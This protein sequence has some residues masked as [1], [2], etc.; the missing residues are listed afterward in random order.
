MK[1]NDPR[2]RAR[3][4][5]RKQILAA[6]K[7]VCALRG[8]HDCS[9]RHIAAEAELSPSVLY[10]YFRNKEEIIA[11]LSM[12]ILKHLVV[13]LTYLEKKERL[14]LEEGFSGL[15]RA[16]HDVYRVDPLLFRWVLEVQSLRFLA[17]VEKALLREIQELLD[18]ALAILTRLLT[19]WLS[20]SAADCAFGRTLAV[21][22]WSLFT[23]IMLRG[24]QESVL[25]A[26][27]NALDETL[28]VAFE[29]MARGFRNIAAT[30]G[31][32]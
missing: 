27:K 4:W 28:E 3:E 19:R 11:A 29:T 25:R 13:R 6:A 14:S 2:G 23:G 17:E 15:R 18:Q 30:R 21:I 12:R 32:P 20:L 31:I 22:L 9:T 8:I 7:R 24:N 1:I 5:R 26:R 10:L 16:F